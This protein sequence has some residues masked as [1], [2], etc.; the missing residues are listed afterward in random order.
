MTKSNNK[1]QLDSLPNVI[2]IVADQLKATALR[3][4]SKI[5]I[6][7]PALERLAA[8]GVL[9]RNAIT[10]H[11]LCVPARTSM[12]T[13]RYP[14]ST[15][16]RRNETLMPEDELH[17]FRIWRELGYTT[18][19]IGK[20]HC[21]IEQSDLDLFDVRC[22]MSHSG[23][24][25]NDYKG[26]IPGTQG[27]DWAVPESVIHASHATR[28]DMPTQSPNLNYAIT[29]YQIEGYSSSALTIQAQHFIQQH[30]E[31]QN[32]KNPNP[33]ALLL[34]Y[35][36]PHTP[37]EAPKQYADMFP[38]ESIEM[39]PIR[40]QEFAGDECPKRNRQLYEMLGLDED[41]PE[42]IR[43]AM[44][45]YLAMTR[46]VDDGIG[47]ILGTLDQLDLRKNTIIVFTADHGDFNGEHNMLGKGGVFYDALVR[48]PM[49]VS[50]PSG[51]VPERVED[52]SMANT[53]DLL[54]TILQLSGVADFLNSPPIQDSSHDLPPPPP[55]I[56]VQ[57]DSKWITSH[58]FRRM[59]GKPLPTVTNAPPRTV[60]FSEY[61]AGGNALT[62]ETINTL[63][64]QGASGREMIM[65]TL[66]QRE[67]EG[68]RRMARTRQ[69]KFVTD[70]DEYHH[71][72][73]SASGAMPEDELYD[74]KNDP[75]ELQNM[76]HKSENACVISEMRKLMLDWA[77][78][79]ENYN[80]VPQPLTIGRRSYI[81][82]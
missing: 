15:G 74:L 55:H 62:D 58:N 26:E 50:W 23:L 76:A 5:G 9:Y 78:Q 59:Q 79:T 27:M 34:S 63:K 67:A 68:R 33:F 7:T 57:T 29:D 66:W 21:F 82:K 22:E 53:I 42:Q 8:E 14:H 16:C 48:V 20:N 69:W 56:T 17:A 24:P 71:N 65:Q 64:T 1:I 10:P 51:G 38:P 2:F 77:T 47:Q 11:P 6:E 19:L 12:M 75:W 61:G 72:S 44:A 25:R 49:I 13:A 45:I 70:P 3:M 52:D 31:K 36:D 54:P 30:I 18:A 81:P 43:Q 28:L 35:P 4:Y 73:P 37:L 41:K 80:P 60:A 32:H 39:P 46:F 40:E